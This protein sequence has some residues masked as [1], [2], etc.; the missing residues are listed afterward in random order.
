MTPRTPAGPARLSLYCS[1]LRRT[2]ARGPCAGSRLLL[3]TGVLAHCSAHRLIPAHLVPSDVSARE[4]DEQ[5][6]IQAS[7]TCWPVGPEYTGTGTRG[8]AWASRS[9][10][11]PHLR[12][13][14]SRQVKNSP[15][16]PTCAVNTLNSNADKRVIATSS[17]IR[18]GPRPGVAAGKARAPCVSR[19][20]FDC[21][22]G[23]PATVETEQRLRTR[24]SAPRCPALLPQSPTPTGVAFPGE[25]DRAPEHAP[26]GARARVPRPRV[27][28]AAPAPPQEAAADEAEATGR[29]RSNKISHS[30]SLSLCPF[31][32]SPLNLHMRSALRVSIDYLTN[33]AAVEVNRSKSKFQTRVCL[34]LTHKGSEVWRWRNPPAKQSINKAPKRF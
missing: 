8:V 1:A 32:F 12:Q 5:G 10:S 26:P 34:V 23:L 11:L 6:R 21:P 2:A 4:H 27:Q 13:K 20:E 19:R 25:C 17:R 29:C 7:I 33:E 9:L 18:R 3:E 28:A 31:L 15:D 22:D 14:D 30:L 16:A 24:H